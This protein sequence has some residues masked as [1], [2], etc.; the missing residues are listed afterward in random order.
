VSWRGSAQRL[1]ALSWKEAVQLRRDTMMLRMIVGIPLMQFLVFAFA[2]NTEVRHAPLA[3]L[4]HD[5]SPAARELVARLVATGSYDHA[6]ALA[7]E[8]QAEAALAGGAAAAV[9][10]IP[11]RFGAE[12]AAGH[13]TEVQ[14]RL[15]A[16]DP[17]SVGSGQ[18]AVAGL[19]LAMG[20]E[21]DGAPPVNVNLVTR[22][23]PEAST[24]VYIVPGLVGVILSTSLV[25]LT[26]IALARER[27]RGT[28]EALYAS[29]VRPWEI[30]VGK[31]LPGIVVGYLQMALILALGAL[32]FGIDPL[33]VL[34][35]LALAG[36][37]F[38]AA[39]LAIGLLI[40]TAVQTQAQAM[41][42]ALLT[43]LPNIL[44]SGFMFPVAAM[45]AAARWLAECLPLT[46][47]LRI[48]RGLLLKGAELAQLPG[49]VAALVGV[50][51]GLVLLA[52][53]RVRTRLA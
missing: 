50:L 32:L 17:L 37:L 18:S 27:E 4:D 41:Q 53:W 1:A 45:P 49:D 21:R 23:N 38:I 11:P 26:A 36:G 35:P 28:L 13:V 24:A 34:P 2:I 6:G 12:R 7:D 47:F 44:L 3:V 29:P 10:V 51:V 33:P 48:D 19:V 52:A 42:L 8:R 30:I 5:H 9:L 22:Y 16:S 14:V 43:L 39:N 15:D 46:H 20:E 31:L 40:S 25:L